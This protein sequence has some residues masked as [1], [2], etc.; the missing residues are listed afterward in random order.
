MTHFV[1]G[2][3]ALPPSERKS[4]KIPIKTVP[5]G[6]SIV[7]F[8]GCVCETVIH[9][10]PTAGRRGRSNGHRRFDCPHCRDGI[11]LRVNGYAPVLWWE[12]F[13]QQNGVPEPVHVQRWTPAVISC[14]ETLT[15][16]LQEQAAVTGLTFRFERENTSSP[17]IRFTPFDAGKLAIAVPKVEPFDV[18]PIVERAW[19]FRTVDPS[20]PQVEV[21]TT[22]PAAH[23]ASPPK[24]P[25][26]VEAPET[27]SPD[28][29]RADEQAQIR[30]LKHQLRLAK[31]ENR[32]LKAGKKGEAAPAKQDEAPPAPAPA[33]ATSLPLRTAEQIKASLADKFKLNGHAHPNG[34]G[35]NG[36]APKAAGQEGGAA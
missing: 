23:V 25:E 35:T 27:R 17:V 21:P 5:K 11:P 20:A 6:V 34:N 26:V 28:E 8:L 10:N 29:Q 14:P 31:E 30:R 3:S 33:P 4:P 18:H 2:G 22:A 15:G 16:C 9:W 24:A 1:W 12:D 36:H 13:W 32:R 19:G 7:H